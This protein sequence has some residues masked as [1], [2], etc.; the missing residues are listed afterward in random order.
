L[1]KQVRAACSQRGPPPKRQVA[2]RPLAVAPGPGSW[3]CPNRPRGRAFNGHSPN[4]HPRPAPVRASKVSPPG[5]RNRLPPLEG[6]AGELWHFLRLNSKESRT[7]FPLAYI[8]SGTTATVSGLIDEQQPISPNY[9]ITPKLCLRLRLPGAVH[10]Y[11]TPT[12]LPSGFESRNHNFQA[13]SRVQ[14]EPWPLIPTRDK[15]HH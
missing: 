13:A 14:S 1:I 7:Q 10:T 3:A 6:L 2:Q 8:I 12:L 9:R 5:F 15:T 11:T 4:G